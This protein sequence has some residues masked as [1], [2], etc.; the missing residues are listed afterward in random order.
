MPLDW[1]AP[2]GL[3]ADR[4][5]VRGVF[6]TIYNKNVWGG[7]SGIGSSAGVAR[8][9]MH[10]L[11]QFL[12]N[13]AI[14]SVVDIG[15]GDWQFSQFINWGDAAYLGIDVVASVIEANRRQFTRP[16]V[17]FLQADP[18]ED[19]F[20]ASGDLLLIKD[21]M[22]HLSNANVQKLLRLSSRFKFCLLTNAYA[23]TNDDCENGDT[24]A[25]D[26]R[27]EPFNLKHAVLYYRFAEK[28]TFLLVNNPSASA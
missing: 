6:E 10:L 3:F 5:N 26:I 1:K 12:F 21:V 19:A 27:A 7:G 4:Q 23:S 18:L 17:S 11:Q 25:L 22:Q 14:Q 9:Y 15:C 8:P 13:N 28:A 2:P 24:R 16:N 20:S